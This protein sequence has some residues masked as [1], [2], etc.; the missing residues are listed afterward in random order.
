MGAGIQEVF[1][2]MVLFYPIMFAVTI[3]LSVPRRQAGGLVRRA[4]QAAREPGCVRC[5]D[6]RG[7]PRGQT[8]KTG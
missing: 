6:G 5:Q 3:A 8:L 4:D 7:I 1:V 2:A